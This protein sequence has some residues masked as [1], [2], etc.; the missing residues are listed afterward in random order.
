[1]N[2]LGKPV[3]FGRVAR[4]GFKFVEKSKFAIDTIGEKRGYSRQS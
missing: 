1:M 4:E 2:N 3:A